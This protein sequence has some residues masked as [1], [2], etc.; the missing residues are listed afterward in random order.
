MKSIVENR[1]QDIVMRE[2]KREDL[3]LWTTFLPFLWQS[4]NPIESFIDWEM[5]YR[6]QFYEV[7]HFALSEISH[8]SAFFSL[9]R[10]RI[11]TNTNR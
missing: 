6:N 2:L 8:K 11:K 4:T 9:S 5:E 1:N 3:A 7:I 10:F